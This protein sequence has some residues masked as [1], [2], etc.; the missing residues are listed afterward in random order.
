MTEHLLPARGDEFAAGGDHL[1]TSRIRRVTGSPVFR[2]AVVVLLAVAV[3][4]VFNTGDAF[5]LQVL[6]VALLNAAITVSLSISFGFAG[7]FNLSQG[8]FYGLGAYTAAI[9]I[10]DVNAPFGLALLAAIAVAGVFGA[11]MGLVSI[12]LR[13]DYFAFASIAFTVIVVQGLINLPDL[14]RGGTGFFGIPTVDILGWTIDSARDSFLLAALGFALVFLVTRRVTR[15][16]FGRAMLAVNHDEMSAKAMGVGVAFTRVVAMTL[17]SALAGLS[18]CLLTVTMLY[19]QPSDF[20][21]VL[22]MNVTLWSIIGGP[23]S[24]IGS[25]V[26]GGG[27]T[28]LQENIRAIVDYR[29]AILGV[30]VL[31][32]VY[33]RGGVIR[34]PRWLRLARGS[35]R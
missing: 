1:G 17:S 34:P 19:I 26:A 5:T 33:L 18:G 23:T 14:T 20:S 6:T 4:V 11:L 30:V 8:S 12:R 24:L 22:S 29:L 16:F 13:D 31:V 3:V 2:G 7:V 27:I 15:S 28:F 32:A 9:L 35:R 21:T 25:A 10:T